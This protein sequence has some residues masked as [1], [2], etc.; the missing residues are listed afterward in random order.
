MSYN[1][2]TKKFYSVEHEEFKDAYQTRLD[3]TQTLA[4]FDWLKLEF[5]SINNVLLDFDSLKRKSSIIVG[6]YR[7]SMFEKPVVQ[8]NRNHLSVGI[9]CHEV[10]HAIDFAERGKTKHDRY[11]FNIIRM[12]IEKSSALGVV[13]PQGV[14]SVD[15]NDSDSVVASVIANGTKGSTMSYEEKTKTC[16][17]CM[18]G[19]G[20]KKERNSHAK[21][22]VGDSQ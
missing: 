9:V 22:C 8:L 19:F 3:E 21:V 18:K 11:L 7:R 5:P 16:G 13:N 6:R 12:V 2:F 10:S 4:L 14:L 17:L 15:L 1:G 20:S